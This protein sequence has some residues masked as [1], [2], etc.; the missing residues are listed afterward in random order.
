MCGPRCSGRLHCNMA[1]IASRE[2]FELSRKGRPGA[3]MA[4]SNTLVAAGKWDGVHDVR[5]M[6]KQ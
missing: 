6:M 4:F 1:N 3:Y 2:V 5:E